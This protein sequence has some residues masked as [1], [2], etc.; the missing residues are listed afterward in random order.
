MGLMQIPLEF[1]VGTATRGRTN[2][3]AANF[4][5]ILVNVKPGDLVFFEGTYDAGRTVT[6]V[7]IY[8]GNNMMIHCGDPIQY[9]TLTKDYW[10]EHFYAYG[11]MPNP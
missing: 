7:G 5:P 6:H 3:F 9:D 4:M 10:Q 11:R 8:V 2:A 1:V